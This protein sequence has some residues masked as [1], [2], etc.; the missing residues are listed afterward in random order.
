[1]LDDGSK[2]LWGTGTGMRAQMHQH[3]WLCWGGNAARRK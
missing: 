2:V 3:E 1:V